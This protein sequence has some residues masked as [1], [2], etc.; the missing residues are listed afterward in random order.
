MYELLDKEGINKELQ[1][2]LKNLQL[3]RFNKA[4]RCFITGVTPP[5]D[6][7]G[8]QLLRR[9]IRGGAYVPFVP[10]W[11][12]IEQLN[13]LFNFNWDFEIVNWGKEGSQ[14]WVLGKLTVRT[15]NGDVVTK[16]QFGGAD[17]KKFSDWAGVAREGQLMDFADDLK[18]AATDCLKKCTTLL[19]LSRDVYGSREAMEQTS[20]TSVQMAVLYKLVNDK[21]TKETIDEMSM[22]KFGKVPQDLEQIDLLVLL[23]EIRKLASG[24]DR[25]EPVIIEPD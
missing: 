2:E 8:G 18:A 21:V 13:S 19:G 11:W 16:T 23:A 10:A 3:Q 5:E 12:M 24:K 1:V 14:I 15:P 20:A 25:A 9:Q 6:F 4:L 17:V 7:K 22:T